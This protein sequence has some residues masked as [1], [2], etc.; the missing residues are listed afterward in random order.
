[1]AYNRTGGSQLEFPT[2]NCGIHLYWADYELPLGDYLKF[3]MGALRIIAPPDTH[4]SSVL[5]IDSHHR[6]RRELKGWDEAQAFTDAEL[7]YHFIAPGKYVYKYSSDD[8]LPRDAISPLG[9]LTSWEIKSESDTKIWVRILAGTDHPA[10]PASVICDFYDDN[11]EGILESERVLG[12]WNAL[13]EYC[14]PQKARVGTSAIFRDVDP[15][16]DYSFVVGVRT[17]FDQPIDASILPKGLDVAE[18]SAGT[19]ISLPDG[20]ATK[21]SVE[22]PPKLRQLQ[23]ALGNEGIIKKRRRSRRIVDGRIVFP[24][25]PDDL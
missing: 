10:T 13:I 18:Q 12:L 4:P 9:F 17:Y 21:T 5:L 11:D 7:D 25:V 6:E 16:H 8:R 22:V 15:D 3:A 20:E 24:V 1:M 14:K 2:Y 23:V 19:C